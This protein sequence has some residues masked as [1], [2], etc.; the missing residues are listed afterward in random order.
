MREKKPEGLPVCT[1]QVAHKM[2]AKDGP[3]ENLRSRDDVIA[4]R[5]RSYR[6]ARDCASSIWIVC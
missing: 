6:V 2:R 4:H 3:S 1:A 5:V